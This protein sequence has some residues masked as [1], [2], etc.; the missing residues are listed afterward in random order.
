MTLRKIKNE[1]II[2][3]K[4]H[5]PRCRVSLKHNIGLDFRI[6]T[7]LDFIPDAAIHGT[8]SAATDRV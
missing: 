3:G 4:V 8:M 7:A 5:F 6:L 1:A 2:F